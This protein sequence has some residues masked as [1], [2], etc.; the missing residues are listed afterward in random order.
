V[1]ELARFLVEHAV[2][3]PSGGNSQPWHFY[4]GDDTLWVVHDRTRSR[5]LLD[6]RSNAS[7]VALL[8]LGAAIENIAVAAARRGYRTNI[9]AFPRPDDPRTVAALR[10]ANGALFEE[11]EL[12][13]AFPQLRARVTNRRVSVRRPLESGVEPILL[14][15]A[16]SRAAQLQLVSD[17]DALAEIGRI[18]GEADR[19]R[20]ACRDLHRELF[21]ELR[22]TPSE[23]AR[24][25]DGLDVR[26]LELTPAQS[27]VL[28]VL[29]RPDVA[30]FIRRQRMGSATAELART[31][32]AAASAVG[33]LSIPSPTPEAWLQGGRAMERMWLAATALGVALQPM[34]ALLFMLELLDDGPPC[35]YTRREYATLRALQVRLDAVFGARNGSARAMLFRLAYV[36]EPTARS[37]RR[38]VASVLDAGLPPVPGIA[39]TRRNDR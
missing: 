33:L 17:G 15:A 30:A 32:I 10:F 37:K 5:T 35:L 2:L 20:F 6:G 25:Q 39:A 13:K 36:P 23:A 29:A 12:A 27:A 1:S 31:S 16:R 9:Q 38:P 28:R 11:S 4:Y 14:E 7:S 3:A 18:L 34:T 8:A 22:W 19:V 24:T 26:T 21:D